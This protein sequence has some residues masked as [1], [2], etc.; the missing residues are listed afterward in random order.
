[1]YAGLAG[2]ERQVDCCNRGIRTED[3]QKRFCGCAWGR[4]LKARFA[5]TF[6]GTPNPA[7]RKRWLCRAQLDLRPIGTAA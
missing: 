4:Q 3:G 2:W 6:S 5:K 7:A 1:M